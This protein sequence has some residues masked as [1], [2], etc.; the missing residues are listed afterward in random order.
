MSKKTQPTFRFAPSP[1]GHLHIGG[2]RTAIFNWLLAKKAGGRFLLRIE[3]T[4]RNRSTKESVDQILTSLNWLGLDWDEPPVY[5]S[6]Q[7]GLHSQIAMKLLADGKAYRCFCTRETLQ[8]K[9]VQAE[10]EKGAFLYDRVC[11]DLTSEQIE[12]RLKMKYPFVIRLKV[13][14]GQTLIHDIIRGDV[15]INH[16]E[17]DD[18]VILRSDGSPVY[19]LAVVVDDHQMGITHVIRGEDHLSN[20]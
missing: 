9:R 17:L 6:K 13:N 5:Q 18:F 4:D 16:A 19:Q 7:A 10:K 12:E 20:T 15:T 11:R 8:E 1:T 2:A 3:D 14:T